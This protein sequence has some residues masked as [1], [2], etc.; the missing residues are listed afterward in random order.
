MPASL[1]LSV[2]TASRDQLQPDVQ[3]DLLASPGQGSRHEERGR[4]LRRV[5]NLLRRVPVA[6]ASYHDPL[7]AR[8]D[9]VE[10]DY[11]RFRR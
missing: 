7:F 1:A 11:Y 3:A 6:R 9:I 10:N 5:A 2:E 4:V 8:P